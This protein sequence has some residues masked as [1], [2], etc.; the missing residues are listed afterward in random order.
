MIVDTIIKVGGNVDILTEEID[1]VEGWKNI[2][3]S[4][5]ASF[6]LQYQPRTTIVDGKPVQ[7]A[8]IWL[9]H[10]A[11]RQY[12]GVVFAPGLPISKEYYNLWQGF[13]ITRKQ[14][15]CSLMLK[16]ILENAC[17]G[18]V[19]LNRYMVTWMAQ[20]VQEPWN[21]PGIA[22]VF[23]GKQ[24]TGKGILCT[25]F[26]ALFGRHFS[27]IS[28]SRHLVGNF[29]ADFKESL[30]VFADEAYWAGDKAS[31]GQLKALIT[32]KSLKLEYKGKDVVRV[33][34]YIRLMFATN[35]DWAVP[36]GL[37]E[38]RFC[39]IDIGETHMQ[40]TTYFEALMNQMD[41]G[42]RE[43]FLDYLLSYDIST[44]NLRKLPQTQGLIDTK[45]LT[46]LNTQ[47]FW[48][49]IL[50]RGT[51]MDGV[52]SWHP[53]INK[54]SLYRAYILYAQ[55]EKSWAYSK[56]AFW[57]HI[58]KLAPHGRDVTD[59]G[60]RCWEVGDLQRCRAAVDRAMSWS[61]HIWEAP[62][63]DEDI[64]PLPLPAP[65]SKLN[66]LEEYDWDK[67]KVEEG[68]AGGGAAASV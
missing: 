11:R 51:L 31:E 8:Q 66:P 63:V 24:G 20:A 46:F 44:V 59:N 47:R 28:T 37:E 17:R 68:S 5:K 57:M 30:I 22:L 27:H 45:L 60:K 33:R 23:R 64:P 58:K 15:D 38:R 13:G 19:T 52:S 21:R 10:P 67:Y 3:F 18:D 50:E 62:E 26:G 65:P 41:S 39:V 56:I 14:G 2:T 16:H 34:N 61:N 43:A 53:L 54:E 1:P 35:H 36:A 7:I 4:S 29:N 25:Q 6:L 55:D 40:D 42:G 48:L 12:R 49:E 9:N 32:E